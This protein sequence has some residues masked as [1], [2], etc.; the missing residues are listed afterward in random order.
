MQYVSNFSD[1]VAGFPV[2]RQFTRSPRFEREPVGCLTL[3]LPRFL[4][5]LVAFALLRLLGC[6]VVLPRPCRSVLVR[7]AVPEHC[8]VLLCELPSYPLCCLTLYPCSFLAGLP[9]AFSLGALLRG[10]GF[11]LA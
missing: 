9:L 7:L 1:H 5:G 10:F 3:S 2:V 11:A 8:F 4:I 6:V